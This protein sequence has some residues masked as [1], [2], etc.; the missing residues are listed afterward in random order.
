MHLVDLEPG[1]RRL[2]DDVLPILREL[3]PHLSADSFAAVY[4]E[5]H[6]QGLR[7]TALYTD[8]GCV[9]VAGWRIIATTAAMRKLYIDDLVTAAHAR[10]RGHGRA[11]LAE[12]TSR[13]RAWGCS[14]LDLDSNVDRTQ[15]HRFYMREGLIISS[16]HF[17]QGLS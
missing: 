4:T 12:L 16:F 3:R 10:S 7:Y 5:A 9:A 2:T 14:V 17:L 13:A 6:P 8:A 1:D 15:A 11:L